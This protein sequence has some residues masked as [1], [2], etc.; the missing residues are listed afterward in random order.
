MLTSASPKRLPLFCFVLGLD[1][2]APRLTSPRPRTEGIHHH[3]LGLASLRGGYQHAAHHC[4]GHHPAGEATNNTRDNRSLREGCVDAIVFALFAIPRRMGRA[5]VRTR[6]I[7]DR[8][9]FAFILVTSDPAQN[10]F[11]FPT[12]CNSSRLVAGESCA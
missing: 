9:S 12:D 2:H 8:Q 10:A 11:S 5:I 4:P 3:R 1:T 6:A 7:A